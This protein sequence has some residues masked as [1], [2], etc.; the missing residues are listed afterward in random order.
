MNIF[1]YFP[2]LVTITMTTVF[3]TII[4][5]IFLALE[6][7]VLQGFYDIISIWPK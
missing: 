2:I 7:V 3:R 6:V 5:A 4:M 1:F